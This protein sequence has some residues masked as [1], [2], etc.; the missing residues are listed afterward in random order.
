MPQ[1]AENGVTKSA[2]NVNNVAT[3]EA[4][5]LAF[6][7]VQYVRRNRH[8]S[9]TRLQPHSVVDETDVRESDTASGD[10]GQK[11]SEQAMPCRSPPSK[12]AYSRTRLLRE[13]SCPKL[14]MTLALGKA[15]GTAQSRDFRTSM[16][17]LHVLYVTRKL[18]RHGSTSQTKFLEQVGDSDSFQPC[19][20]CHEWQHDSTHRSEEK[21][22]GLHQCLQDQ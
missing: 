17:R 1:S 7:L 4:T 19:R 13:R 3:V 21:W 20:Q 15:F 8:S 9:Q 14:L 11:H 2:L 6:L 12:E 5:S 18:T 22:R 10:E 16:V